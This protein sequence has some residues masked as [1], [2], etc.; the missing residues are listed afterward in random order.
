M[1]WAK[2]SDLLEG[3]IG[4]IEIFAG[5]QDIRQTVQRRNAQLSM[6]RTTTHRRLCDLTRRRQFPEGVQYVSLV[7][8]RGN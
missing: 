6:I 1:F 3:G 4:T 8:E 7:D 5:H 2:V